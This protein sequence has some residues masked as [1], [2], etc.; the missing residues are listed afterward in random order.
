M[1]NKSSRDI[2]LG[3]IKSALS[4]KNQ[5]QMPDMTSGIFSSFEEQDPTLIFAQNFV[6]NKGEFIFCE[7]DSEFQKNIQAYF[8]QKS[9]QSIYVW[10]PKLI[11]LLEKTNI[12]FKVN[13]DDFEAAEAGITSCE[14]LISRTGSIL[15]SSGNEGGRRLG[16]FPHIHIVIG[17]TSQIRYDIKDGLTELRKKYGK[18]LPSMISLETGP[19]RTSDIEKTLVLGAHGPKDLILF[20]IDDTHN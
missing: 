19:S 2:I 3:K 11:T 12:K 6:N 4:N 20:L 9:L 16:I 15:V 18:N 1:S 17:F 14:S 5:I 7:N 8:S 10:E 13:D